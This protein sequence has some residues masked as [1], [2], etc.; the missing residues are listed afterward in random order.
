M[1]RGAGSRGAVCNNRAIS[2]GILLYVLLSDKS[3]SRLHRE[4][5]NI[6][7]GGGGAK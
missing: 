5:N 2:I 1:D 6:R 3:T 7:I 4:K